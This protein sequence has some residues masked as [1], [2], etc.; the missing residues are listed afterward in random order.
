MLFRY[1][2]TMGITSQS[3]KISVLVCYR[4][5]PVSPLVSSPSPTGVLCAAAAFAPNLCCCLSPDM[6]PFFSLRSFVFAL[7]ACVIWGRAVQQLDKELGFQ[8]G[9]AL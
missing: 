3:Q 4:C 5:G 2:K 8:I 6:P 9:V 1:L 7:V